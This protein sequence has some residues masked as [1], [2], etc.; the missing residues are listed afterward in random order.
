MRMNTHIKHV[1]S[2]QRNCEA[3][4]SSECPLDLVDAHRFKAGGEG[5]TM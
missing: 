2:V 4:D 1:H 5:F 3:V